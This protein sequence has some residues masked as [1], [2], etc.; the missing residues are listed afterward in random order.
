MTPGLELVGALYLPVLAAGA[1]WAAHRRHPVPFAPVLLSLLWTLPALL[2]LQ[3]LNEAAGWW[4]FPAAELPVAGMPLALW[5]GWTILWGLMPPLAFP[6]LPLFAV[7]GILAATDLVAMPLCAAVV[8]L[9]PHWLLG[10]AVALVVVLFPALAIARFTLN[11]THLRFRA[12]AQVL[13]AAALFLFLLPEITFALRPGPGWT[14][15]LKLPG[16]ALQI[17]AQGMFLLALP[18]LSAVQEFAARG[19]GTPIPYDAPRRLVTSGVYRFVANPMQLSCALA[20]LLWALVLRNPWSAA[21][22]LVT[23]A[24]SA[25]LAKWDEAHDLERR[26]GEPWSAYRRQVHHWLPRW[27]PY[28]A[29]PCIVYIARTCG[30][31]QQLRGWIEARHPL[32]LRIEDAESLPA[33]TMQ[34]MRYCPP[35]GSPCEEGVRALSRVLEHLTLAWAL[36]GMAIRVPGIAQAVQLLA[37]LSGFGPRE[38]SA[39]DCRV[40]LCACKGHPRAQPRI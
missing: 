27:R 11:G 35:D 39:A 29:K 21:A 30:V 6:R 34:R 36:T 7:A 9:G 1:G 16:W 3:R 28:V 37:D 8:H 25:G 31:C 17:L 10:E 19:A 40:P 23:I 32:G 4:S 18:G 12:V 13:I 26:F 38:L 33:G 15:L 14:P 22:A 20:L 24:Y 5:L 2:A